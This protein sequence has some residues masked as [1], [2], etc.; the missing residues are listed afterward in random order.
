LASLNDL[1]FDDGDTLWTIGL[2]ENAT[3]DGVL[4]RPPGGPWE[5]L[6]TF[7]PEQASN[8]DYILRTVA[9]TIIVSER[10]G[11][12]RS[13]DGGLTFG[14]EVVERG[15]ALFEVRDGPHTGLLLA[16]GR[17]SDGGDVMAST[18]DGQT[19][20]VVN[21][22]EPFGG[23]EAFASVPDGPNAGRVVAA[24]QNG[25]AYSDDGGE[26]WQLS[27]LW[28][29]FLYYAWDLERMPAG[30]AAPG[31]LFTG[32]F[33]EVAS[34]SIYR[35]DDDGATWERVRD[36]GNQIGRTEV[37]WAG[38]GTL[39]GVVSGGPVWRSDDA[40]AT[41]QQVG[42]LDEVVGAD[43]SLDDVEV[44]PEGRLWV[45]V[46]RAGPVGEPD[47]IWR[48]VAPVPV[49]AEGAPDGS[50]PEAASFRLGAAYP[51]PTR[52]AATVPVV[53]PEAAEV[54]VTVYD[55]LGRAV[56]TL[57]DGRLAVGTHGLAFDAGKLP[58]GVYAVRVTG[59]GFTAT[60]RVTV[61]R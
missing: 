45:A 15:G 33:D 46:D 41:W 13:T 25:L 50:T 49:A 39:Y 38:A 60:R 32:I 34:S 51:N 4:K 31:R 23:A 36:F 47:G 11:T 43:T 61:V 54:R 27:N 42:D 58:A 28:E 53:V 3:F 29:P 7:P 35:S 55:V 52:G 1:Y 16:S 30:S 20:T 21:L 2:S 26:T 5:E 40:G 17:A 57:H 44:G 59:D 10:G 48:T 19:W 12:Y 22:G 14:D 18:D 9:G 8:A 24:C 56:A 37:R 6:A